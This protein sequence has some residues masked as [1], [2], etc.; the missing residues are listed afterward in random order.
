MLRYTPNLFLSDWLIGFYLLYSAHDAATG[1]TSG[2]LSSI[3][4]RGRHCSVL[5]D[6]QKGPA[7]HTGRLYHE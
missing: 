3:P 6:V 5:H 4:T 7:T 2:I 1:R